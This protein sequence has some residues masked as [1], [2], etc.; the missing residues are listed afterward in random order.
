MHVYP[1]NSYLSGMGEYS[2]QGV[3]WRYY[4]LE[5]LKFC[6]LNNLLKHLVGIMVHV[7]TNLC[8]C[9]C[10]CLH[11]VPKLILHIC[12]NV[13]SDLVSGGRSGGGAHST[14]TD[15]KPSIAP[16]FVHSYAGIR[17]PKEKPAR[18]RCSVPKS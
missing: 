5:N 11:L 7:K 4:L 16:I 15:H 9:L 1:S 2:R 14:P 3:V 6:A 12:T 10:L 8:L 17:R 13:V 18:G